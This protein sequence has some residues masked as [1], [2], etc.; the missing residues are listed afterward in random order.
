MKTM[1]NTRNIK[2][3]IRFEGARE[4]DWLHTHFKKRIGAP[5]FVWINKYD[6]LQWIVNKYLKRNRK[7]IWCC[8]RYNKQNKSKKSIAKS[9]WNGYVI[10]RWLNSNED[11]LVFKMNAVHFQNY[12]VQFSDK[13]YQKF[14][15]L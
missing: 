12:V 13:V 4:Y 5:L 10:D 11:I 6:T 15:I 7:Y 8:F 9:R 1:D 3:E 2:I 14:D